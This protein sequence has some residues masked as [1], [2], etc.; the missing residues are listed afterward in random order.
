[1]EAFHPAGIA[2]ERFG[3]LDRQL[4]SRGQHEDL[5]FGLGEIDPRQQRQ[6]KRRGLAGP[7]LGHAEQVPPGEQVRN[8]AGLDRGRLLV[9]DSLEGAQHRGSQAEGGE[10]GGRGL[11]AGRRRRVESSGRIVVHS[12]ASREPLVRRL[13]RE[14]LPGRC[15]NL[16]YRHGLRPARPLLAVGGGRRAPRGACCYIDT[17]P[18]APWPRFERTGAEIPLT[19]G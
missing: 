17:P 10:A 13:Y 12:R 11:G 16:P 8:A 4:A 9:A 1:M 3:H 5:G 15:G 6:R 19:I 14:K 2:L 18:G 7:G